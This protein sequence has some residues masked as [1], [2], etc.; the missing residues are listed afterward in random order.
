MAGCIVEGPDGSGK[1][2]LIRALRDSLHLPVVHV[3]QPKS[4][5]IKQML[6]FLDCG[7]IIFDRFSWSPVVY[8][9]VLRDGPELSE[10][11]LW[12][13]DGY[14]MS[15]GYIS[16]L[17]VTDLERMLENNRSAPQLWNE[18]RRSKTLIKL[19]DEYLALHFKSEL[20]RL[21]FDYQVDNLDSVVKSYETLAG[22]AA[23]E[24]VLGHPRPEVWFVGDERADHGNNGI[25]IPFYG[26]GI[27]DKLLSGTLLYQ[28]LQK[29]KLTWGRGVALS[30]SVNVDLREVYSALGEPKKV[31]ALGAVANGRLHQAGIDN[32]VVKHPQWWRRFKYN[33]PDGYTEILK[34]ATR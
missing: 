20:P 26:V 22:P 8:G 12:A 5:D 30:N 23:P 19:R 4:P 33:D 9:T 16:V 15:R 31:V 2:T 1:T 34:K 21:L 29:A 14:L 6:S 25:K 11:D 24:H 17:C 13:L 10:Y 7:P 18:V 28:A 3:V 27:S 32:R